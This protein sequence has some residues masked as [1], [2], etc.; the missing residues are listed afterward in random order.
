MME[1]FP[2]PLRPLMKL[3][4]GPWAERWQRMGVGGNRTRLLPAA[5]RTKE[6]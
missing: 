6:M 5:A 3:T 4:F 2:L 1:L